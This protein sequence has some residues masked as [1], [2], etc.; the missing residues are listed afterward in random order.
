MGAITRSEGAGGEA[1]LSWSAGETA[2]DLAY[3]LLFSPDGGLTWQVLA[4]NTAQPGVMVPPALLE[5][6]ERPLLQVQASDG[7]QT[8]VT[9][10]AL[11]ELTKDEP[12]SLRYTR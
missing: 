8:A 1:Q 6:A 7:V 9:T 11:A 10:L 5:G 2:G 4:A 12:G 3:R